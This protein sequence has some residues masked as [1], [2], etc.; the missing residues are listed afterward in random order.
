[1]CGCRAHDER[2]C[3]GFRVMRLQDSCSKTGVVLVDEVSRAELAYV[4]D[5]GDVFTCPLPWQTSLGGLIPPRGRQ[6]FVLAACKVRQ[7]GIRKR[8][9][10]SLVLHITAHYATHYSRFE[11][12]CRRLSTTSTC[13]Q[14]VLTPWG[15]DLAFLGLDIHHASVTSPSEYWCPCMHVLNQRRER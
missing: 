10:S 12:N 5:K 8:H 2:D 13:I 1:M 7:Q 11:A 14:P 15:Q 4:D 3:D 6:A 9:S